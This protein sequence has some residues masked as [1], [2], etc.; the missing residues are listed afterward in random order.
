V[1]NAWGN[2]SDNMYTKNNPFYYLTG[3]EPESGTPKLHRGNHDNAQMSI[4]T[5]AAIAEE[6]TRWI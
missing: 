4:I 6:L 2:V 3:W 5:Q 1:I